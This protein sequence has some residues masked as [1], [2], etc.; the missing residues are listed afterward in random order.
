MGLVNE[1]EF[2]ELSDIFQRK[3]NMTYFTMVSKVNLEIG[4]KDNLKFIECA[5]MCKADYIISGDKHL[6]N[7]K[8]Y[9]NIK[10]LSQIEFLSAIYEIVKY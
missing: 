4:D 9:K 6:L 5:L 2:E 8:E 1:P 3:E 7:L 10:I